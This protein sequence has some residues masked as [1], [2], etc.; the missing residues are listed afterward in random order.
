MFMGSHEHSLDPKGRL[1]L[2]RKFRGE[3]GTEMVITKG[4]E[5]CLYGFPV[6]EFAASL[7]DGVALCGSEPG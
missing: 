2:P 7:G 6:P 3:L 5:K 1:I 4:I